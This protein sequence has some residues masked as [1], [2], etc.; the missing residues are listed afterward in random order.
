[1]DLLFED[2]MNVSTVYDLAKGNQSLQVPFTITG[3]GTKIV[4]W[5]IDGVAQEYDKN[6]DEIVDVISSIISASNDYPVGEID[7]MDWLISNS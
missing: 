6:V 4:E 2:S 7:F 3:A 5:F 1:M